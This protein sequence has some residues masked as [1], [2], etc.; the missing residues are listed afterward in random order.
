MGYEQALAWNYSQRGSK[1]NQFLHV[2]SKFNQLI[3]QI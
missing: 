2:P 3:Q 1:L